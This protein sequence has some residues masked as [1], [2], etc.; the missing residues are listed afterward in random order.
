MSTADR[1]GLRKLRRTSAKLNGMIQDGSFQD[2]PGRKRRKILRRLRDLYEGL[3]GVVSE[4]ALRHILAAAAVLV[5]GVGGCGDSK[6]KDTDG[7]AEMDLVDDSVDTPGDLDDVLDEPIDD[8]VVEPVDDT[9]DDPVDDPV[10]DADDDAV[11]AADDPVDDADDDAVDAVDV[12][13]AVDAE[14]AE[15]E[16]VTYTPS[17]ATGVENPF[18]FTSVANYAIPAFGDLDGDGD[19]DLLVGEGGGDLQYFQNTGS[20]TSPTFTTPVENPFGFTSRTE[21]YASPALVDLDGDG[22]LD[23][24]VGKSNGGDVEL[25]QNTGTTTSP[26]F[27]TPVVNPHGLS[28]STNYASLQFVDLDDDGDLDLFLGTYDASDNDIYYF[29][30]TGSATAPAFAAGSLLPFGLVGVN[31]YADVAAADLDLDGDVELVAGENSGDTLVFDNTGTASS[32]AFAAPARN[33]HG[34][35]TVNAYSEP[36]LADIDADGDMDLF[37]GE[38]GGDI[39]YF[40]NTTL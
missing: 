32:P 37:I 15:A 19:L 6:K 34:I 36:A 38:A 9:V 2:L 39:W 8:P 26:A 27:A 31:Q 29:Q 33:P 17:F 24:Y 4:A 40:E 35:T 11:D 12:D 5:L 20:A 28:N 18:G 23:L 25:W 22:D 21:N 13:D 30:N 1:H 16:P 10:D 14:D 3:T 7:D